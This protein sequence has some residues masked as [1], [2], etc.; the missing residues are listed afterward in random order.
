M[1]SLAE[2]THQ[3]E[4]LLLLNNEHRDVRCKLRLAPDRGAV[5]RAYL[6]DP[7]TSDVDVLPRDCHQ[8]KE[9]L[10]WQMIDNK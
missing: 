10:D 7:A 2:R 1:A 6:I 4:L 8:K 3:Y 5:I 9:S